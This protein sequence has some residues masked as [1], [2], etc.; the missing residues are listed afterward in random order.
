MLFFHSLTHSRLVHKT[1]K[2][3][4]D[5]NVGLCEWEF[6]IIIVVRMKIQIA[7]ERE[8]GDFI[9]LF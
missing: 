2:K 9:Y 8:I 5:N 7:K 6:V 3:E 1:R 4:R